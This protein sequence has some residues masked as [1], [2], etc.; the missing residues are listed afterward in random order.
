MLSREVLEVYECLD[1]PGLVGEQVRALF[2]ERAVKVEVERLV[3]P[4]GETDFIRVSVHGTNGRR[5]GG[6]AKTLGVIGRLGGMGV[7]PDKIG[8]VSDGDG[9][10][11]ALSVALKLARMRSKGDALEGDIIVATH[12]CTASPILPRQPVDF[13]DSPV[14]LSEMNDFEVSKEMDAILTVDTS[15][16]NKLV[17]RTGYA[18]TPTVKEG[19][20]L[21]VSDDL[22]RVMEITSQQPAVVFP[23]TMQDITPY[24]NDVYHFN[25]LMQPSI[26]TT[27]P[28][29]GVALTSAVQ[30]PGCATGVHSLSLIED[31]GRFIIECAQ[32]YGGG[33]LDFYCSDEFARLRRLYGDMSILQT[34]PHRKAK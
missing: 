3:G 23:V 21:K 24:G 31:V 8:F 6:D 2:P 16:G 5:I 14:E 30:V 13:V 20:I 4:R 1:Q 12:M 32:E 27:A 9:A 25:S 11:V 18:I 28:L 22:L 34:I 10:L 19:W 7:R 26:A 17:N 29:V 33:N 15:R